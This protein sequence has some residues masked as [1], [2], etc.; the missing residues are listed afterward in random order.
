MTY[1]D[2]ERLE[3][4]DADT[5]QATKPYPWLNPARCLTEEGF[6]R[7]QQTLPEVDK[8]QRIFG[9]QRAYGQQSHDRFAL[10]YADSLD[11]SQPWKD[12]IAELKSTRYRRFLR[13]MVGRAGLT[14]SY[15]W[16]YT[17]HGCSVSPHCDA[18]HKLGSHI[19]Y[20]NTADDWRPEW[21]GDTVVLDDHGRFDRKSAPPFEAF[22]VVAN[23]NSIG[24]YSLLFV[25]GE[26]SWHGV[27][28]IRCPPDRY[29]KVFI[30]VINDRVRM[31]AKDLWARVRGKR[32]ASY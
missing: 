1:L 29:R 19:F 12:F 17:P 3:A 16:H 2:F 21:G 13:R 28:E 14:L 8:F 15:H 6:A 30:V 18:A 5:F 20:F 7:L 25:R 27:R 4:L 22:D 23:S 9:K 32:A 26:G 31:A 24:N 10:E 11:L